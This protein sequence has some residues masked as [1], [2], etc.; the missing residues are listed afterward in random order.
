MSMLDFY[1]SMAQQNMQEDSDAVV[2]EISMDR[3]ELQHIV[4]MEDHKTYQLMEIDKL[5]NTIK[6]C[7]ID[8]SILC[9]YNQN[10]ELAS[11]GGVRLPS[12]EEFD[13]GYRVSKYDVDTIV[14]NIQNKA[15]IAAMEGN[16]FGD[17]FKAWY[18]DFLKPFRAGWRWFQSMSD[19]PTKLAGRIESYIENLKAN[20]RTKLSGSAEI[21]AY[22]TLKRHLTNKTTEYRKEANKLIKDLNEG[23]VGLEESVDSAD[24]LREIRDEVRSNINDIKGSTRASSRIRTDL[25]KVSISDYIKLGEQTIDRLKEI[26]KMNETYDGFWYTGYSSGKLHYIFSSVA[27]SI[28]LAGGAGVGNAMY[29]AS[30]YMHRGVISTASVGWQV[31]TL[32]VDADMILARAIAHNLK[33][34]N[35][36]VK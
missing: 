1:T 28:M 26:S 2:D 31:L 24:R 32:T 19:Q 15:S 9:M 8:R 17:F 14:S 3:A 4:D 13:S 10:N 7:G 12:L 33:E 5:I 18:D 6:Q 21:I 22:N 25:S 35:D 36:A 34:I 29:S 27:S 23:H 20:Q 16:Q 11:L 30:T